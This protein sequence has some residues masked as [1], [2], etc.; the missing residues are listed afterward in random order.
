MRIALRRGLDLAVS[1][2]PS[3][4]VEEAARERVAVVMELAG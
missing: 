1:G 3:P 4:V 2:R